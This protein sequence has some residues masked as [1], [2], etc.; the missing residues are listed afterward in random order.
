MC[1]EKIAPKSSHAVKP[2]R[3]QAPFYL[4]VAVYTFSA[5]TRSVYYLL[6]NGKDCDCSGQMYKEGSL[7]ADRLTHLTN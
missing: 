3:F 5:I 4:V 6:D 7:A 2:D 1:F